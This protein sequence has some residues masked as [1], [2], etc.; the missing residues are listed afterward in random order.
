MEVIG[1]TGGIAAGKSLVS[2]MLAELGAH[3]INAD[4]IGHEIYLPQK[5][6]WKEIVATFGPEVL[7][8]DQTVDR[9]RLGSI[10]F[11]NPEALARLNQITH[12]RIIEEAQQRI[13][14]QRQKERGRPIIFEAAILIE[15]NWLF[16]VD[17]VWVVVADKEVA[18]E[19][20]R[21]DRNLTREQ[22]ESRI[23]SQ[24]SNQ[25]RARYAHVL[26]QNNGTL[27]ELR[28]QVRQAW[29]KLSCP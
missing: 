29:E 24:L 16:L 22:A 14:T 27:E 18:I 28:G 7:R 5:E 11:G 10:V 19:R 20:L 12:P 8:P 3:I 1:L 4:L 9:A 13:E 15:A 26:I 21:R 17:K 23:A 2:Q 25:E 6:A